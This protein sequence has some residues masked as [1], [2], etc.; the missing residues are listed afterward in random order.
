MK[1]K[2]IRVDETE[3]EALCALRDVTHAKLLTLYEALQSRYNVCN[4]DNL[5]KV[6][7]ISKQDL[8]LRFLREDNTKQH[9]LILQMQKRLAELEPVR[10]AVPQPAFKKVGV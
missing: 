6:H 10:T 7:Y 3:Y 9:A 5:A 2:M 1:I 8:T 4:E